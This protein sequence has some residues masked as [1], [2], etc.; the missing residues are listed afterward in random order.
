[1]GTRWRQRMGEEKLIALLQ[2]SLA[3][4]TRTEAMRSCGHGSKI[5]STA[6]DVSVG[7]PRTSFDSGLHGRAPWAPSTPAAIAT[8]EIVSATACSLIASAK[9]RS[10]SRRA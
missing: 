7:A 6:T 4:A 9:A 1:L 8:P 10:L 2:E 5:L 3:V